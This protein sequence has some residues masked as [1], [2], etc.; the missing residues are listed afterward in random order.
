MRLYCTEKA[1]YAFKVEDAVHLCHESTKRTCCGRY[2]FVFMDID[3][4]D[5]TGYE[6]SRAIREFLSSNQTTIIAITGLPRELV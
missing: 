3:L 4:P 6:A 1:D 2:K 5:K